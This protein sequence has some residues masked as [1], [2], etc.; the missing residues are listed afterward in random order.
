V[1]AYIQAKNYTA[2]LPMVR[3]L[4]ETEFTGFHQGKEGLISGAPYKVPEFAAICERNAGN[5]K[6]ADHFDAVTK[7]R[8]EDPDTKKNL[9]SRCDAMFADG[10]SQTASHTRF[11]KLMDEASAH[12]LFG[13]Q[14]SFDK[15]DKA[16]AL[17]KEQSYL[18]DYDVEVKLAVRRGNVYEKKKNDNATAEEYYRKALSLADDHHC[19]PDWPLNYLI[20][21]KTADSAKLSERLR[22]LN[23][24]GKY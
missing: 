21:L 20:K 13:A 23:E 22:I 19:I 14:E 10:F 5:K 2:A 18:P 16:E 15:L 3:K 9:Q 6:L 24:T 12:G 1:E 7:A 8:Q 11:S 4:M 17:Y